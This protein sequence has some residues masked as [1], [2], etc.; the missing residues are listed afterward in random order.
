[1]SIDWEEL[2]DA[3]GDDLDDERPHP[4][5]RRGGGDTGRVVSERFSGLTKEVNPCCLICV[6][7][8]LFPSVSGYAPPSGCGSCR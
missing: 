1:M 7:R 8:L 5:K 6:R 4:R 3:E 2:L